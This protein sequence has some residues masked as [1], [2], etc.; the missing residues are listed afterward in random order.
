MKRDLGG[1]GMASCTPPRFSGSSLAGTASIPATI[2][3]LARAGVI[4]EKVRQGAFLLTTTA[5]ACSLMLACTAFFSIP[6]FLSALAALLVTAHLL[7]PWCYSAFY[8]D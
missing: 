8:R 7:A 6:R 4:P 3:L 5:I 2:Y 1:E